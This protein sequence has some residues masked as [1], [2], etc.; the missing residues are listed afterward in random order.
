[1]KPNTVITAVLII[2][3]VHPAVCGRSVQLWFWSRAKKK[4]KELNFTWQRTQ[5]IFF[6]YIYIYTHNKLNV[7]RVSG[8]E[9]EKVKLIPHKT[10]LSNKKVTA[11]DPA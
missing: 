11:R 4:K 6:I 9:T 1:M 8:S 3:F 5:I 10:A 7:P 2:V